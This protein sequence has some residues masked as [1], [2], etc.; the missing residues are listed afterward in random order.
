MEN[1]KENKRSINMSD[2]LIFQLMIRILLPS[3]D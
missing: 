3:S 2:A 1:T